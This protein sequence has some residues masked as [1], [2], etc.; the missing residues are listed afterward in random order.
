ML[1][2]TNHGTTSDGSDRTYTDGPR[3]PGV[4]GRRRRQRQPLDPHCP[5]HLRH[6]HREHLWRAQRGMGYRGLRRVR[7]AHGNGSA[8]Q[9]PPSATPEEITLGRGAFLAMLDVLKPDLVIVRG[10]TLFKQ[11][12]LSSENGITM[13]APGLYPYVLK[14]AR[15]SVSGLPPPAGFQPCFRISERGGRPK[16]AYPLLPS[17]PY[18]GPCIHPGAASRMGKHLPF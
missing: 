9:P 18:S 2:E 11:L 3:A 7:P 14:V 6:A 5:Q 1:G 12:W 16:T 10:L 4:P 15:M 8:P 17:R 13:L